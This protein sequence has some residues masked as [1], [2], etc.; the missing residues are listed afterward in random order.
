MIKSAPMETYAILLKEE[1]NV[2]APELADKLAKILNRPTGELTRTFRERP[3]ILMEDVL[4]DTLDGIFEALGAAN[5]LAR[6]VPTVHMPHWPPALRIREAD[7]TPKGLFLTLAESP[8]PPVMPWED[9]RIISAGSVCLDEYEQGRIYGAWSGVTK[10]MS[11]FDGTPGSVR[12]GAAKQKSKEPILA[13]LICGSAETMRLRIDAGNFGY[14]CLKEHMKT[15][16]RENIRILLKN[17][18]NRCPA[19]LVTARTRALIAGDPT[20]VYRFRSLAA[21]KDYCRWELQ[22]L[23]EQEQSE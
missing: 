5:V 12:M 23:L 14:E 16:S 9:I 22:T 4:A 11:D 21:F 10:G 8:A 6:A 3:W 20:A 19:A 17:I 13:E 7:F 1:G 2:P 18:V 15:S